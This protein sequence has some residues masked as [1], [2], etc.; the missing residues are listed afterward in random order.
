MGFVHF[1]RFAKPD[2]PSIYLKG[3]QERFSSDYVDRAAAGALV[4][5]AAGDDGDDESDADLEPVVGPE[6]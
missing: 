5:F 4:A 2:L 1:A 6:N 3:Q